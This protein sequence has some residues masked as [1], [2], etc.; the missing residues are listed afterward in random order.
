[1]TGFDEVWASYGASLQRIAGIYMPPGPERED[2][3]QEIAIA[4]HLA[5]PRFRGLSSLRTYVFRIAHNCG[6]R[7]AARRRATADPLDETQH[8]S[9]DGSDPEQFAGARQRAELLAAAI[10]KLPLGQRQIIALALEELPMREIA[11]V[12]GLTENAANVRLHRARAAL[13]EL[14]RDDVPAVKGATHG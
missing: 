4:I 7:R 9:N 8:G 11:Q 14:M 1:M 12:L 3:Q 13:R 6:L 5:L 2:L 10:R